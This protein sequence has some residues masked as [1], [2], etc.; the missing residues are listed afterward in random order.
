MSKN[1]PN[2]LLSSAQDLWY[3]SSQT[4]EDFH[5]WSVRWRGRERLHADRQPQC[6]SRT[7]KITLVQS[8]IVPSGNWWQVSKQT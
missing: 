7:L 3:Q 2:S 8:N 4:E 6:V 5:H 1:A